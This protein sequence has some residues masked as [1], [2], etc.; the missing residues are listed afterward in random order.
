ME[1]GKTG[2]S[3][4]CQQTEGDKNWYLFLMPAYERQQEPVSLLFARVWKAQEL[5]SFLIASV[6]KMM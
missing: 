5:V 2:L 3:S 6:W 4:Y 1:G